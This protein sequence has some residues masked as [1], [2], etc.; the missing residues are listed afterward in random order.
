MDDLVGGL[1]VPLRHFG[2]FPQEFKVGQFVG[3]SLIVCLQARR[4]KG[5]TAPFLIYFRVFF[6][7]LS[8][9]IP[10]VVRVG[11]SSTSSR[12]TN[13]YTSGWIVLFWKR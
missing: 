6:R 10:A 3:C 8:D 9:S 2:E 13:F 12:W 5:L 11:S 1:V 4:I 7:V